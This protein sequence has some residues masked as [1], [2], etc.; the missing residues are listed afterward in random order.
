M[1]SSVL[2][3]EIGSMVCGS[4]PTINTIIISRVIASA[5]SAGMYLG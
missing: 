4:A 5:G 3:F 1:I 2:F